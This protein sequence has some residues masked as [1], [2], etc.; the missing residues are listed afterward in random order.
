M[1]D[2]WQEVQVKRYQK[3]CGTDTVD[4]VANCQSTPPPP[5]PPCSLAAD[6]QERKKVFF[7]FVWITKTCCSENIVLIYFISFH[8][9]VPYVKRNTHK[10]V[11]NVMSLFE[12]AGSQ[13]GKVKKAQQRINKAEPVCSKK[14][15]K[16]NREHNGKHISTLQKR[17]ANVG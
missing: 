8:L 10:E 17:W 1:T 16:R 5:H 6:I 2:L 7:F 3:N 14:D 9:N 13:E 4:K 11:K 15:V 12:D